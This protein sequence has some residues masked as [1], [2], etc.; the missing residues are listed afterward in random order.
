MKKAYPIVMRK[1][2]TISLSGEDW[3]AVRKLAKPLGGTYSALFHKLIE[4]AVSR[5]EDA[6]KIKRYKALLSPHAGFF[7]RRARVLSKAKVRQ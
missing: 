4:S 3:K 2:L 5:V 1:N 6:G 7:A